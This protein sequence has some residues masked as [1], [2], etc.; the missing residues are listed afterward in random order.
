MFW[1]LIHANYVE[2]RVWKHE[3]TVTISPIIP[4]TARRPL[5][6]GASGRCPAVLLLNPALFADSTSYWF[7][8]FWLIVRTPCIMCSN[9]L[10]FLSYQLWTLLVTPYRLNIVQFQL[11]VIFLGY[12]VDITRNCTVEYLPWTNLVEWPIPACVLTSRC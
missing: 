12:I 11:S 7:F 4:V 8:F 2:S 3:L 9:L 1:K 5:Q 6:V 10:N